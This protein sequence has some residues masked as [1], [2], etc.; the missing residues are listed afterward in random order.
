MV[1]AVKNKMTITITEDEDGRIVI[2]P[3]GQSSIDSLV[4]V[5]AAEMLAVV[6]APQDDDEEKP[7]REVIH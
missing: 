5:I 2:R 7:D 4:G 6:L 3:S 1:G